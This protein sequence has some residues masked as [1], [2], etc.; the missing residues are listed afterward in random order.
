VGKIETW[1]QFQHY[2]KSIF[3]TFAQTEKDTIN[4]EKLPN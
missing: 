1:S 2:F 3:L 4:E